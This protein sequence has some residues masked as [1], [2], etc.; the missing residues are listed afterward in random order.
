MI[1]NRRLRDQISD[2]LREE[3]LLGAMRDGQPL[4]E[5][6][7]ADRFGVSRIPVRDALL[8]LTSEG[9]L[10]A[11][12]NRGA[13]VHSEWD[14]LIRPEMMR[15]RRQL[16]CVALRLLMQRKDKRS[17]ERL[18]ENLKVFKTACRENDL[19]TVVRYDMGFHRLILRE[20]GYPRLEAVWLTIMGGMRLPYTRHKSLME[21]HTEHLKIVQAIGAGNRKAAIAALKAN[22]K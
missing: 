19:S 4:R 17:L 1:D 9:L 6:S 12:P 11:E 5:A 13:K 2:R 10:I 7:L 15:L 18:H 14:E 16:E 3:I 21:S 22:I 20:S 8:Q